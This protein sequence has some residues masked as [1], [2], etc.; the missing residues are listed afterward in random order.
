M[1]N[2]LTILI[3]SLLILHFSFAADELGDM[4][5][6]VAVVEHVKDVRDGLAVKA[7]VENYVGQR[8]WYIG[9]KFGWTDAS[10]AFQNTYYWYLWRDFN[11]ASGF[12]KLELGEI[13]KD[14][15]QK[16]ARTTH[17]VKD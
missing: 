15:P 6:T 2:I 10:T 3:S 16:P 14:K 5:E 4:L 17:S 1:K 7:E 8:L 12:E 9:E 11:R 13:L